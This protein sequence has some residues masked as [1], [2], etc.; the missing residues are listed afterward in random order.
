[1]VR[2]GNTSLDARKQ[3]KALKTSHRA[4]VKRKREERM[5]ERKA[6]LART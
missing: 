5:N 2:G 4:D 6:K 3:G 1:M